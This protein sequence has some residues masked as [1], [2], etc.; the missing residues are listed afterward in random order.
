[1]EPQWYIAQLIME[2]TVSGALRNVVHKNLVLVRATSS[3]E[4]YDKA[5]GVGRKGETSYRN[6]DDA[7]VRITFRG[8]GRLDEMYEDLEDGSELMFEEYIGVSPDEIE[9]WIPAKERLQVFSAPTPG[10]KRDPDYRSKTVM[11]MAI[12]HVISERRRSNS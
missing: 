3:N 5:V 4:A 7:L 6:P 11:E 2:I 1:M 8:I 9:R 12:D 10:G